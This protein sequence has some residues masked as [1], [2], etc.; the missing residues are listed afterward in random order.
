[1]ECGPCMRL[2]L[3][4]PLGACVHGS[5]QTEPFSYHRRFSGHSYIK[6]SHIC[7]SLPEDFHVG[8]FVIWFEAYWM[9]NMSSK[10]VWGYCS[11]SL[12]FSFCIYYHCLLSFV[13]I[14]NG[15]D[16]AEILSLLLCLAIQFRG[17]FRGNDRKTF[18]LFL[19]AHVC[20]PNLCLCVHHDIIKDI[21]ACIACLLPWWHY[22]TSVF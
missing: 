5:Y 7:V 9:H 6:A 11:F 4:E 15:D 21:F 20:L 22:E 16:Y 14:A 17:A 3:W 12:L 2:S 18:C 10:A 8:L 13:A 19:L 1:M